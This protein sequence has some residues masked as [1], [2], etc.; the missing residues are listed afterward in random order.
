MSTKLCTK[1]ALLIALITLTGSACRV[2]APYEREQLA[3]PVMRDPFV[4]G[5][6]AYQNKLI[7]T[8]TGGG[9]PGT[10]VGGGCG[11]TQ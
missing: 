9:L 2:V 10:A 3:H 1:S 8:R 11:C 4:D 7:Q 6:A 5:D